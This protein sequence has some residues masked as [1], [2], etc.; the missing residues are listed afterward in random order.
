MANPV[1][2]P[3]VY[4]D[5]V[6]IE[7]CRRHS[8]GENLLAVLRETGM[9]DWTTFWTR[10]MA[11]D[12]H[13]NLRT[14]YDRAHEA[15]TQARLHETD[16]IANSQQLGEERTESDGPKG[17]TTSVTTSDVLGHRQLQVKTRMWFA[18]RLLAKYAAKHALQN[19]DGS[20]VNFQP[21]INIVP[22]V[23]EKPQP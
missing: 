11:S 18:E 22:Y 6:F 3:I 17:H 19:P 16:E 1:G 13:E 8:Q 5:E 20:A 12:A 9:P 15:W 21:V 2:H 10:C 4:P 14:V 7:I 23:P